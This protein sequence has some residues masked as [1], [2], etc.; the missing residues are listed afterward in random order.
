MVCFVTIVQVINLLIY[1]KMHT[2]AYSI[3]ECGGIFYIMCQLNVRNCLNLFQYSVLNFF[4]NVFNF[5][6]ELYTPQWSKLLLERA[7][8][9]KTNVNT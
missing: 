1:C 7:S 2:V 9:D 5:H 8:I 3:V 6:V 4:L